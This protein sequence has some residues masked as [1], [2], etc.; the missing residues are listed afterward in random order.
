MVYIII[1]KNQDVNTLVLDQVR[2]RSLCTHNLRFC[3]LNA[4][5]NEFRDLLL[6]ALAV[7]GV[8]LNTAISDLCHDFYS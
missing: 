2:S 7:L 3:V 6:T 5:V 4:S 1:Q 8:I